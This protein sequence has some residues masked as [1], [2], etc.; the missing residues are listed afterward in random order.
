MA[1]IPGH[2]R[3]LNS[4]T[5]CLTATSIP[6]ET[7]VNVVS[8]NYDYRWYVKDSVDNT[9]TSVKKEALKKIPLAKMFP[10]LFTGSLPRV[11]IRP[12]TIVQDSYYRD[13]S[14]K[15]LKKI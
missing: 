4:S 7:R 15:A 13:W 9:G 3:P 14:K 11:S 5:Y 6:F 2:Y 12:V 1:A 8:S 10:Y